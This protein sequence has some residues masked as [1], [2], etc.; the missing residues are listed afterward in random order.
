MAANEVEEITVTTWNILAPVWADPTIYAEIAKPALNPPA[1]RITIATKLQKFNS[2]LV[3]MEEVEE[4]ELT[5]MR[6]EAPWIDETYHVHFVGNDPVLWSDWCKWTKW[7]PNGLAVLVKKTKFQGPGDV[8]SFNA[9]PKDGKPI[10]KTGENNCAAKVTVKTMNGTPVMFVANHLDAESPSLSSR[11][12]KEITEHL[13][14]LLKYPVAHD[15]DPRLTKPLIIWCGDFNLELNSV[16]LRH[17]AKSSFKNVSSDFEHE[18]KTIGRA[19]SVYGKA[20]S[21]RLDHIYIG[22]GI[23]CA[24]PTVPRT[25]LPYILGTIFVHNF[26]L[27]LG[28]SSK[29]RLLL[30]V[31]ILLVLLP[32][33]I[34]LVIVLVIMMGQA[35]KRSKWSLEEWG[36]DHLPVTATLAIPRYHVG[37]TS[38]ADN[39]SHPPAIVIRTKSTPREIIRISDV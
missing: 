13:E 26:A 19:A 18:D 27:G 31:L 17:V 10:R 36:S 25:D 33:T 6:A 35:A 15:G 32:F 22:P 4:S 30:V 2:D 37:P 34:V 20:G 28:E 9:N 8:D 39:S 1:R 38:G 14:K 16:G 12:C 24:D 5:A 21:A 7:V 11:Q 3:A 29:L 23:T